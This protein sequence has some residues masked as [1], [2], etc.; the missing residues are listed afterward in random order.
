MNNP[1]LHLLHVEDQ[2]ASVRRVRDAVCD[3]GVRWSID[4]VASP[5]AAADALKSDRG[6]DAILLSPTH[7]SDDAMTLLRG[8]NA[9]VPIIVLA[10]D[11]QAD[12]IHTVDRV[13]TESR[14]ESVARE[15]DALRSTVRAME[16]M[17]AVVGHELRTPLAGLRATT[18]FLL[19]DEAKKSGNGTYSCN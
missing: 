8:V 19:T 18:E 1:A 15:C 2:P 12:F 3:A 4:Q 10:A 17:M 6:V 16:R 7:A 14:H 11:A 9:H 13:M 5:A